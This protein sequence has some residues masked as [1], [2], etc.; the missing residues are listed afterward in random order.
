MFP[1]D[2]FCFDVYIRNNYLANFFQQRNWA[3]LE[4]ARVIIRIATRISIILL[5]DPNN[6]AI[7]ASQIEIAQGH[8]VNFDD[9]RL[10]ASIRK[11]L[12]KYV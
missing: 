11:F 7:E 2:S 4:G 5:I 12:L 3:P 8:S 1:F 9:E 10:I 6:F